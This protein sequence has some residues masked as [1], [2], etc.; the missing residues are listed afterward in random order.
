M[1]GQQPQVVIYARVSSEM[2]AEEEIPI[3]GQIEECQ[4]FAQAQGWMVVDVFKDEGFSGRNTERPALQEL[5]RHAHQRP[6]PFEKI[7]V[8]KESR[9][10]RNVEDRYAIQAMLTPN[11]IDFVCAADA[12]FD[13]KTGAILKPLMSG[14]AEYQS[15][16]ISEDTRRGLKLLAHQGYSCG[17]N[18][19]KGYRPRR[20]VVGLKK[21]GEPRFRV[22]WEPDPEWKERVERAFEMLVEGCS[23]QEIIRETGVVKEPSAISTYFRNPTFIGER[24]YNVHRRKKPRG[25]VTKYD[26]DDPE[27]VRIP[28]AHEPI[29]SK[30]LWDRA[31][32]VLDKRRPQRGQIRARRNDFILSGLLWCEEHDCSITGTGNRERRYYACETYRRAGRRYSSCPLLRKDPLEKFVMDTIKKDVFSYEHVKQAI[33]YLVETS[34]KETSEASVEVK[35]LRRK[36]AAIQREIDNLV[37]AIADGMDSQSLRQGMKE[38]ENSLASLQREL[39]RVRKNS[40]KDRYANM[41][42]DDALVESTRLEAISM[43]ENE[44]PEQIRRLLR[45]YIEWIKVNGDSLTIKFTYQEPPTRKSSLVDIAGVGFE[46][47]TFGL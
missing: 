32:G 10:A 46:P 47:T 45:R 21:N 12:N 42:V 40:N 24:V 17:G 18:P 28:N 23:S 39:D 36:M 4:A 15:W 9:I 25:R 20:E 19:P 33:N 26:L 29:I 41:V 11:D 22:T 44:E 27:V 5:L 8:W 30:E 2:Q 14:L 16:E 43:L 1:K 37:K 38:R 13:G 3:Q 34:K 35:E 6:Q 31:Q 7:V